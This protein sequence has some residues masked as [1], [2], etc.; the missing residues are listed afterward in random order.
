MIQNTTLTAAVKFLLALVW[1]R[2][3]CLGGTDKNLME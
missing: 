3:L 2:A 1:D